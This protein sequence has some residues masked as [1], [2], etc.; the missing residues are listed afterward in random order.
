[1]NRGLRANPDS[2]AQGWDAD[3]VKHEAVRV[4]VSGHAFEGSSGVGGADANAESLPKREDFVARGSVS[5]PSE[6]SG[7]LASVDNSEGDSCER[8]TAE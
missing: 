2:G 5:Y 3:S 1:M 7:R 6:D 8:P 4:G